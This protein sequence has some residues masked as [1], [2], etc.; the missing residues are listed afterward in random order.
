MKARFLFLAAIVTGLLLAACG[1]AAAIDADSLPPAE[2]SQP[3]GGSLLP[4]FQSDDRLDEQGAVTVAIAPLNLSSPG[5]T[6][7]FQVTLDT[8]SVD[9]SM[10]LVGLSTLTTDTGLA[11]EALEWDAPRGGH[12]VGGVLSFPAE[13]GGQPLLEGAATLTLTIREVGTPERIFAWDSTE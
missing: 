2:A 11:V 9:L 10:D 4:T 1:E 6:L 3:S 13:V 8:H 7:D 5:E 12:H